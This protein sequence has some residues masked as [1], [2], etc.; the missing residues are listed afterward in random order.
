MSVGNNYKE[1]LLDI[2][3]VFT[4]D[5]WSLHIDCILHFINELVTKCLFHFKGQNL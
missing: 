4:I 2:S 1:I 5:K 3:V